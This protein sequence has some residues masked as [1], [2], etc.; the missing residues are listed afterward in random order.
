MQIDSS[1]SS[2]LCV[3]S[4]RLSDWQSRMQDGV[5]GVPNSSGRCRRFVQ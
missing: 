3:K 5:Q 2:R 4:A 1:E